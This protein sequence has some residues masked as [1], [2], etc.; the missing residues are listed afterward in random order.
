MLLC[1]G[2]I[3]VL[4]CLRTFPSSIP[5][6]DLHFPV[7]ITPCHL[8]CL[9]LDGQGLTW[10]LL[11]SCASAFSLGFFT[12]SLL[13]LFSLLPPLDLQGTLILELNMWLLSLWKSQKDGSV[14]TVSSRKAFWGHVEASYV[15]IDLYGLGVSCNRMHHSLQPSLQ[16][17]ARSHLP[18]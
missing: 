13:D 9:W 16:R 18:L 3:P 1:F 17:L 8:C 14:V 11:S 5:G 2:P 15:D 6:C 7:C 12:F 4:L 10:A